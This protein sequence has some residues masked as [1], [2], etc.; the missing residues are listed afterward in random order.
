M[1]HLTR[2]G[3]MTTAL[4]GACSVAAHPWLT[5]VAM[6]AVPSDNRLV[7]IILRGA[8]DGLDVVRPMADPL[9]AHYRP[10]LADSARGHPLTAG[11]EMHPALDPLAP[12]W[13]AGELSFAH[14]VSTPYRD[15]RSHFDGQDILE[16]GTPG[17]P[18]TS[19]GWL[20][21]LLQA[22]PGATGDT[23]FA[24]GSDTQ[25]ILAGTAAHSSWTPGTRLDLSSQARLLLGV[26]YQD[27]AD[28][29]GP[30]EAA[31]RIADESRTDG[32]EVSDDALAAF[33]AARLRRETR[34]AAFSLTGWDT[35]RGQT[36]A[37]QRPLA[38]L[39]AA[40]LRLKADLGPDWSKTA[41][42]A[43]T[44]FGRTVRQNG[45]AGTDHGTGGVMLLAGGAIR[46]GMVHGSWPGL[47][48]GQL[49]EDRDLL[50]TADVRGYAAAAIGGLF[51]V[52]Q[53]VLSSTV[54]PGLD[55]AGVPAI[56][57]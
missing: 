25:L 44:E 31:L 43:M 33:A 47:G 36:R 27:D 37:I 24:V 50:P 54:F 19:D 17:L 41:V 20:N 10:M 55:M 9:F 23:A 16:A 30:A 40:V 29:A 48:D 15:K 7:V 46:G 13:D 34:I 2:R 39:A 42:L 35:H 8:M 32:G 21:R 4:L 3:L 5:P 26:L 57:A 18:V 49:F 53:D 56:L 6:A 45:S 52:P 38:A 22:M 12:M 14:A 51:G 28:F 11:F 1:P